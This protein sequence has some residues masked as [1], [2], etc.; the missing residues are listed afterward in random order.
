MQERH[1][2]LIS[3]FKNE[4][5]YLLKDVPNYHHARVTINNRGQEADRMVRVQEESV[6]G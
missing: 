4:H 3:R 6:L 1:L 5:D 2:Y